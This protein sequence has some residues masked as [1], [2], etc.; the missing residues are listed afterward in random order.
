MLALGAM[1]VYAGLSRAS[2]RR[3]ITA[4]LRDDLHSVDCVVWLALNENPNRH[5]GW[6]ASTR[7]FNDLLDEVAPA[8]G[9]HVQHR[10]R[11]A[12]GNHPRWFRFDR[13]HFRIPGPGPRAYSDI[14]RVS[15]RNFCGT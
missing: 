3:R 12:A 5:A 14:V 10:W 8:Y 11:V 9:A 4:V 2:M 15:V 6:P 13:V 7:V 1:D